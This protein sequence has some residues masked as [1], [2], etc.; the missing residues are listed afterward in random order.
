MTREKRQASI[1]GALSGEFIS[2][3][4]IRIERYGEKKKLFLIS[5]AKSVLYYSPSMLELDMG[6]EFLILRGS[7]LLCRTFLSGAIEVI[8]NLSSI[9]F[10][11]VYLKPEEDSVCT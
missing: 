6:G 1:L 5:G 10:S 3:F 4:G 7:A 9:S 11:S 2:G 8:G